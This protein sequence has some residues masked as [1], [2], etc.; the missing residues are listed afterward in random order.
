MGAVQLEGAHAHSNLKVTLIFANGL[1]HTLET[2][3]SVS[4]GNNL[5]D[6]YLHGTQSGPIATIDGTASPAWEAKIAKHEDAVIRGK[7]GRNPQTQKINVQVIGRRGGVTPFE[8][9]IEGARYTKDGFESSK[10]EAAM[11]T[12]GGSALRILYDG[13]APFDDEEAAS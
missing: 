9:T 2:C 8:D 10:G 12:I 3:D 7:M 5:E 4:Y 13:V 1:R 6:G 11:V